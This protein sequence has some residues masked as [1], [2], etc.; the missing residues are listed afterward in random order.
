[1]HDGDKYLG[2]YILKSD[3]VVFSL[4]F[5]EEKMVKKLAGRRR[6]FLNS[7]GRTTLFKV[8]LR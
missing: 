6:Y 8:C 7:A 4:K 1:M 5:L 3:K 2:T